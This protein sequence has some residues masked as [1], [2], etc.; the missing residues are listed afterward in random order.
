MKAHIKLALAVITLFTLAESVHAANKNWAGPGGSTTA[1]V[2]GEWDTTSI[3]WNTGSGAANATFS[4]ADSPIFGG[5]DGTYGIRCNTALTLNSSQVIKF[6]NSGYT[7]TNDVARTITLPNSSGTAPGIQVASGKTAAIGTNVTVT[8][9]TSIWGSPTGTAGGELDI[10]NGGT[11][12]ATGGTAGQVGAGTVIKVK[13]GGRIIHNPGAIA[14]SFL[15]GSTAGD[16]STL[17]VDGG[18]VSIQGSATVVRVGGNGTAVNLSGTL[19]INSGSFSMAST[20]SGSMTLGVL[21]GNLG[22]NNLNGGIESVNRIVQGAGSGCINFNGGTLRAVTNVFASTFLNG[23]TRANV[24]DGGAVIDNNGFG[25]TIGQALL[26]SSLGG[27]N[28]TDGGLTSSGSGTNLL[29]G[30]NTYN[31]PTVVSS[32]TLATTT[33]STGGG[34]YSVA[35]GATL[36]VRVVGGGET[37]AASA[38]TLGTVGSLGLNFALNSFAS[39][40][41]PA[42]TSSGALTLNGAVTVNVSGSGFTGPNSYVLL[43]Y[44][45][46]GGSGSFV[47]GTIPLVAGYVASI[48]NDTTAKQLQLV[49]TLAPEPVKWAVG[50]GDWNTA[51]LN[52][53]LLS[54]AGPTNYAEG[55]PVVFDESAS[56]SS[57]ITIALPGNRSPQAITNSST[58]DYILTGSGGIIT[59]AIIKSGGGTLVLDNSGANSLSALTINAGTVQI[60]N[61]DA[62]GSLGAAVVANAGTLRFQRSDDATFNNV[63]SGAGDVTKQG[64]GTITLTGTNTYGGSTT[65]SAGKLAVT[66]AS[67][68][69]GLYTVADGTTLEVQRHAAGASLTNSSLTLGTSGSLST[70]FTLGALGSQTVPVIRVSGALDLNGTVMVNVTGTGLTT[71][72][73]PLISYGSIAGSG[74]FVLASAPSVNANAVTLTNDT[75]AMQLKLV[76][77]PVASMIWDAGNTANGTTIDAANG[78]WDVN[79]ANLSWNDNGVNRPWVNGIAGIFGGTDGTWSVTLATNVTATSLTFS[80]S[81]Y[82]VSA[83]A[84]QNV[85]LTS[86]GTGASPNLKVDAGKTVALGTNVTLQSSGNNNVIMGGP[87]GTANGGGE[88][89]VDNGGIIQ[90]AGSGTIGLV[91]VGTVLNVKTG[92]ML[93]MTGATPFGFLMGSL[94]NDSCTLNVSGGA[95]SFSGSGVLR[96]GGNG[97]A[98]NVAG[99]LNL[100]S[101]SFSMDTANTTVPMTLGVLSG[102]FGTNNLNGGT[103]SVNR[104]VKGN[105]G[106]TA[107]FNFN[108]GTLRAVNGALGATFLNGLDR[109]NVRDGGAVIDNNSFNLT[110]GQALVHSDV[111]GDDTVDGGL[112]STGAGTLTLDGVNTYTGNTTISNGTLALG[113]GGSIASSPN[114]TITSGATFD[115][116]AAAPWTLG[117][118][119]T[120]LGGGTVIGTVNASGTIAAG[121]SIGTLTFA[122]A[123]ALAGTIVAELNRTNA[124]TADKIVFSGGA[125]FGGALTVTNIG[126]SLVNGDSFDLFDGSLAGSFAA[127]NLPHGSAHWNTSDLNLGGSIVFTNASPVASNIIMGVALGETATILIIGGKN[128]P[129]DADGDSMTITAAGPASSGTSGFDATHITYTADG[130][131]GT[132]TFDYTVTDALGATD[133]KTITVI[134]YNPEGFNQISATAGSGNAYLTYLGIPGMDYALE[135]TH[136]LTPP[137]TWVPVITN[138]AATNGYL[139][140]TNT[141]SLTPT[142][143]F[144]RTHAVP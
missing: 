54:G 41:T 120:L 137:I 91:G 35:D 107:I 86:N 59:A 50:D 141:V 26:H 121:S 36:E 42:I 129:T 52:W 49:Y 110:L 83:S 108:G 135:V 51:D 73:Y 21:A 116:T 43:S 45:S 105:A 46:L 25:I 34:A 122:S 134:V 106:A 1:P 117:A 123:P 79:L 58:K 89:D 133:T 95:V 131:L 130:A 12:T 80:N 16:N 118:S 39:T 5:A 128:T 28:A 76:Y 75:A 101:G 33:A 138:S 11:L 37:L 143:D 56:G 113:A 82:T 55:A 74:S 4:T 85:T 144:Y 88:I 140:F 23:L 67:I 6:N 29:T 132:N 112:T 104:I 9:S 98:G 32:G 97:T 31:G 15:L 60:G 3:A 30:A 96:I 102:N 40:T 94:S 142:N 47:A 53:N 10:E 127:L 99:T 93:R 57:P 115:V 139:M 119:Q 61:D 27:D 69:A 71:G 84:P 63:I 77:T 72:T 103:L 7:L 38:V 92:G 126:S 109:A 14:G 20:S 65:V 8:S 111:A 68:G 44:D 90:H 13:L 81:G 48:T 19:T 100:N 24:R 17:V 22:T 70:V 18:T 2:S 62:N 125:T 87:A 66:T 114:V 124:Q 78:S 64:A 136:S